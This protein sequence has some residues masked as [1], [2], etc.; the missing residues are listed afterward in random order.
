MELKD[1]EDLLDQRRKNPR[2][3]AGLVIL[4]AVVSGLTIVGAT[5]LEELTRDALAGYKHSPQPA[6]GG[7][8]GSESFALNG[9]SSA[10]IGINLGKEYP[11]RKTSVPLTQ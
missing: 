7:T 1:V 4:M 10:N 11:L 3:V 6:T 8:K 2:R 5:V 9:P